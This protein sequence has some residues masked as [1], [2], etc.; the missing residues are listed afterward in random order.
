VQ[1]ATIKAEADD[2]ASNLT[3]AKTR[4]RRLKR[5]VGMCLADHEVEME[6]LQGRISWLEM[7]REELTAEVS[8]PTDGGAD[9]AKGGLLTLTLS[10]VSQRDTAR[11]EGAALEEARLA[12]RQQVD[13]LTQ[14]FGHQHGHVAPCPP[15]APSPPSTNTNP[16]RRRRY[17]G[18]ASGNRGGTGNAHS[19]ANG[20]I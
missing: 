4:F 15:S 2:A 17:R 1:L 20:R 5:R 6:T 9:G 12:L 13:S 14:Q 19:Q 3:M 16:N 18:N 11:Q 10:P 7:C 8:S